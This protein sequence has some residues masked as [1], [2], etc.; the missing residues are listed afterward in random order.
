M[1][2]RID[3]NTLTLTIPLDTDPPLS[4]TGKSYLLYSSHGPVT[5][6]EGVVVS[7][8]VMRPLKGKR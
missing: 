4:S 7:L 3:G 2:A 8:N 5:V 6:A 1:E